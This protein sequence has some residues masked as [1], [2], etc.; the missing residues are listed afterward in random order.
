MSDDKQVSQT[1]PKQGE[2]PF[3]Q[4]FQTEM[5]RLFDRFNGPDHWRAAQ[6]VPA[7]NM[8]ESDTAVE[9]TVDV[10]GV[11]QQD[12]DVSI[13]HDSLIIKGKKSDEREDSDKDWHVVERSF[14]SFRRAI[15]LGFTPDDKAVDAKYENGVLSLRIEKPTDADKN[16]RKI[17]IKRS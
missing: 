15:P 4:T 14:G 13:A 17:E 6:V 11:E 3:L 8:A 9:V 2:W 16:A 5:N 10:P 12:L 7:I 1:S